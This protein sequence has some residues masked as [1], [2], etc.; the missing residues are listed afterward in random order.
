MFALVP[1]GVCPGIKGNV[2]GQ[3]LSKLDLFLRLCWRFYFT[4]SGSNSAVDAARAATHRKAKYRSGKNSVQRTH[5]GTMF[6]YTSGNA[7][8]FASVIVK[9]LQVCRY[10]P[11]GALSES[12]AIR[13]ILNM[14][15]FSLFF[16]SVYLPEWLSEAFI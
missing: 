3:V 16:S 10:V 15:A 7:G 5:F 4:F 2:K 14:K 6:T 13:L 8:G 12:L 1:Q 9:M 11:F